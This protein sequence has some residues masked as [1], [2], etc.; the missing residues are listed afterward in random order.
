M[1]PL[2]GLKILLGMVCYKYTAPLALGIEHGIISGL[3][4]FKPKAGPSCERHGKLLLA[5][6]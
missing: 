6:T 4:S 1:S 5:V 3:R 2:T